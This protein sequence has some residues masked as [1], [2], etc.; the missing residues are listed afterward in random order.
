MAKVAF[1]PGLGDQGLIEYKFDVLSLTLQA[2]GSSTQAVLEDQFGYAITFAGTGFKYKG[3]VVSGGTVTSITYSSPEADMMVI[4]GGS[5]SATGVITSDLDK[6]F[7]TLFKG[8][9]K[10][11]GTNGNDSIIV[12]LNGGNDT[13]L[14]LKGDDYIQG[15]IGDNTIDGGAGKDTLTYEAA[16]VID[17]T[18]AT[19]GVKIDAVKGIATNPWGDTDTF[20]NMEVFF[21]TQFKDTMKGSSAAEEFDG[22]GG[23]DRLTGGKG[24]DVFHMLMAPGN[25]VITDFG[26]GA[27]ILHVIIPMVDSFDDLV[28]KTKGGNT[29]VDFGNGSVLTLLGVDKSELTASDFDFGFGM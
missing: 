9:D 17:S 29:T 26:N 14:G 20:K 8:N 23:N 10:F 6:A 25:D 22:E 3:G 15:S 16:S 21:G 12:G 4:T 13:I 2:G 7:A 28:I 11:T 27:D 18:H 1:K 5:Y 19:H 24:A